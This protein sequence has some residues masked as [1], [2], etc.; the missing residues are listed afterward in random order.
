MVLICRAK[1]PKED[2]DPAG[3]LTCF[4]SERMRQKQVI[5]DPANDFLCL[6]PKYVYQFSR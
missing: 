1:S 2:C 3:G 6:D 4:A 5:I